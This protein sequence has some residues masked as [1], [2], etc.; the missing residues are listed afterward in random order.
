MGFF[1]REVE[2]FSFEKRTS[3][4]VEVALKLKGVGP[5]EMSMVWQMVMNTPK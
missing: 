3:L 4:F 1:C 2:V 5:I